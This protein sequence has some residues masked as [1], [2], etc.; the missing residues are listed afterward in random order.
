MVGIGQS[1]PFDIRRATFNERL[2]LGASY[3][4]SVGATKAL[5][6]AAAVDQPNGLGMSPRQ[7][8]ELCKNYKFCE[9]LDA[10]LTSRREVEELSALVEVR[11]SVKA[12]LGRRI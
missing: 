7:F 4:N 3:S 2:C 8:A 5:L 10:L 12:A 11:P 9:E 6:A 1:Q